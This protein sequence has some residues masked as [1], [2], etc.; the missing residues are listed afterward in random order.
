MKQF[1]LFLIAPLFAF[2]SVKPV[3]INGY[4]EKSDDVELIFLSFRS[5]GASVNDSAYGSERWKEGPVMKKYPC[6]LS[7]AR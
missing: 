6:L 1:I 2:T 5:G 7:R 4:L 3:K